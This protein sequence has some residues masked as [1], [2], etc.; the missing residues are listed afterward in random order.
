MRTVCRGGFSLVELSIVLVILGLL[1]G[2]I[3]AAQS[4]IRASEVRSVG[5]DLDKFNRATYAFRD[6]YFALPGDMTNA[7]SFW[8]A[9][10]GGTANGP[11]STCGALTTPSTTALTCNGDGNGKIGDL[12]M[13]ETLRAWQHLANA[14]LIE[15]VYSGVPGSA[16]IFDTVPGLNSPA[17]RTPNVG[18]SIMWRG[19]VSGNSNLFDGSYMN[20]IRVGSYSAN[21][22][23]IGLAF[24]P[25]EVWNIDTKIDDG[26]PAFGRITANKPFGGTPDCTTTSVS[27]TA[28]YKLSIGTATCYFNYSLKL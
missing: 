23:T 20:W 12:G 14:G 26:S 3:L 11:D 24:R 27:A 17:S 10:A 2:G 8:G 5:T 9:Q 25:E 28:E 15:G 22:S 7:V 6:K 13:V 19:P 4:L 16:G 18:Y 1:V 21:N